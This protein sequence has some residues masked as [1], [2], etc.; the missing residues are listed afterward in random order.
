MAAAEVRAAW[1]RATNRRI[2]QE[3]AR[4]APKF[5][6]SP[7]PSSSNLESDGAPGDCT[8]GR[9]HVTPVRYPQKPN[10]N[11]PS[12]VK[13]WLHLQHDIDNQKDI[14]YEQHNMFEAEIECLN[15]GFINENEKLCENLQTVE[16]SITLTMHNDKYLFEH[17]SKIPATCKKNEL[18]ARVQELKATL[19]RERQKDVGGFWCPDDCLIDLE[20]D[21]L[22]Y[23]QPK[24]LSS[25][26]ESEWMGVEKTEPWWRT[27]GKDELPSLVAQKSLGQIENC[28]LPQPLNKHLR[29][30]P[31]ASME[32]LD[33]SESL[34]SSDW[35]TGVQLRKLASHTQGS[36]TSASVHN[37]S[38]VTPSRCVSERLFSGN[39]SDARNKDEAGYQ[40]S[41]EMDPSKA[42]LLE[43]L[44][45]SQTRAREAEEAA[46]QAYNEKEHVLTL[47]FRQASQLFAYKQWLHI[48]QLENFY[49]QF[50][51]KNA[52]ISTFFPSKK[53]SQHKGR[54]RRKHKSSVYEITKCAVAFAVGLS[55]AG[56]GLLLG[57]TMGWLFPTT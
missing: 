25:D 37:G 24:K 46:E 36:P 52:P 15:T 4:R 44:C 5:S 13:W 8:T 2:I 55:L 16:E 11:L 27:A 35:T 50:K 18:G 47:F 28:D 43:A 56:A 40:N 38:N 26:L 30:G 57:W 39:N 21:C 14:S 6:G 31:S 34:A 41:S 20:F 7:S 22:V 9:D 42:Q 19:A 45:H 3:D 17:S 29:K 12:N 10:S 51:N 33:Y 48:L 49:L 54:R 53:K 23:E 32:F 1:Q